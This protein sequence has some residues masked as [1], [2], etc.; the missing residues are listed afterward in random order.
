MLGEVIKA[1]QFF[2]ITTML[3]LKRRHVKRKN[4][5][6][7]YYFRPDLPYPMLREGKEGRGKYF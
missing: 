1:M 4:K 5:W 2:E 7:S 3:F 6:G